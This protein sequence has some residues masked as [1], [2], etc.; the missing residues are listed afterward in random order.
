MTCNQT[1]GISVCPSSLLSSCQCDNPIM[2]RN[3]KQSQTAKKKCKGVR[4]AFGKDTA[5]VISPERSDYHVLDDD[6]DESVI[7]V[8]S[9]DDTSDEEVEDSME[10]VQ[11]LYSVFD[12]PEMRLECLEENMGE[13]CRKATNRQPMYTGSS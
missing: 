10:V 5:Q 13:K 8:D 4:A 1:V 6:S 11:C 2:P 3:G 9:N 7:Y 12:P